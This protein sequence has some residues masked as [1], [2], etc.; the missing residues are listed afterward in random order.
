MRLFTTMRLRVLG[1]MG[2]WFSADYKGIIQS[3]CRIPHRFLLPTQLTCMVRILIQN[4][5]VREG[6]QV[7][8]P[9]EIAECLTQL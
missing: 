9:M 5:I 7:E 1:T 8:P 6:E 4:V 3:V 2:L